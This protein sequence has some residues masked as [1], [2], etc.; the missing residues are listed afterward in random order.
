MILQAIEERFGIV[1]TIVARLV[2]LAWNLVTFL[3]V[4]I[5]VLED[6]GVGDALE[7]LE[8][9]VQEDLG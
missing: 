2:G 7:A 5:L 9:P 4:P 6:L 8:G 3:V 1:G